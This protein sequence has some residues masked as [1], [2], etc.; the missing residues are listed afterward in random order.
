MFLPA[1]VYL[2][3]VVLT[4]ACTPPPQSTY[5][6]CFCIA[7]KCPHVSYLYVGE[8][9][10][11]HDGGCQIGDSYCGFTCMDKCLSFRMPHD[12]SPCWWDGQSCRPK[13]QFEGIPMV[14]YGD[15][16]VATICNTPTSKSPS[17]SP[18]SSP[19]HE[20]SSRT[21]SNAPSTAPTEHPV[22]E[23]P[24]RR[25]VSDRPSSKTPTRRPST[26]RPSRK[27][28][29]TRRPATKGPTKPQVTSKRVEY[30]YES[31]SSD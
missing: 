22:S 14:V 1:L 2:F 3:S 28:P 16:D 21:P 18:S 25:P 29:T 13:N 24:T 6:D 31:K 15:P 19:T 17:T 12:S 27:S 30:E 10:G 23:S 9:C 26:A 7:N 5:T 8:G 11:E 4:E 20:P